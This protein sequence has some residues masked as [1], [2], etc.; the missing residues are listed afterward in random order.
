MTQHLLAGLRDTEPQLL[1]SRHCTDIA[2]A[3]LPGLHV[4]T[5]LQGSPLK[6]HAYTTILGTHSLSPVPSV[7]GSST[8]EASLLPTPRSDTLLPWVSRAHDV[9][10]GRLRKTSLEMAGWMEP[11]KENNNGAVSNRGQNHLKLMY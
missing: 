11:G 9:D 4:S 2:L 10:S 5:A 3:P 6:Q 1:R 8:R 7:L